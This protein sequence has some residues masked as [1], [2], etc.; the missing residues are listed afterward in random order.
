MP[1]NKPASTCMIHGMFTGCSSSEFFGTFAAV[2]RRDCSCGAL[3][4]QPSSPTRTQTGRAV[5]T[6]DDQL[7]GSVCSSVTHWSPGHPNARPS[8]LAQER[9]LSIAVWPMSWPSAVGCA[10]YSAS[11]MSPSTRQRLCTAITFLP[12]TS[13]RIPSTMAAPSMWNSMFTSSERS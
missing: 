5:Q 6:H 12:S 3:H 10:I 2:L 1:C 13:R 8:C 7:Q 11:Y 9:R 4:C